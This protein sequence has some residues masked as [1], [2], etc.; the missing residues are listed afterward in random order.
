ML[1]AAGHEVTGMTRSAEKT[2]LVQALGATPVV[3]DVYDAEALRALVARVRPEA[4]IHELTDLPA[5]LDPRRAAEQLAGN[6]R[7]R[8]EGTRNLVAAARAGGAR[9]IVAQ[10][11]AFAYRPGGAGPATEDDDLWDDAPRPFA[12]SVGAV[13]EL[14]RAVTRAG[15]IEGVVLRYGFFY[16]PGRAF[17]SDGHFAREARRRRLPL[18][19]HAGGVASFIHVDDAAAATVR[20]VEGGAPGI[21]NVVDDEPAPAREWVP[22]FAA[23]VGAKPPFR[24]PT[25]LARLIAGRYA[26]MLMTESRGARNERAKRTLGWQPRHTSWRTGFRD[27]LG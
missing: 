14:E 7:I 8:T 11:I 26:V 3:C 2:A 20:A 1:V 10:S 6:D 22:A 27:A 16:G 25:W 19:G 24:V 9:R 17:A 4:V 13:R 23:A 18:V 5:A 15:G 12:A 21:Y